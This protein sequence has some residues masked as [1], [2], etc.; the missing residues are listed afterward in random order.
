MALH[1]HE[2]SARSRNQYSVVGDNGKVVR[3][4]EVVIGYLRRC[5]CPALGN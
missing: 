2:V 5:S 3:A 4:L 1:Q